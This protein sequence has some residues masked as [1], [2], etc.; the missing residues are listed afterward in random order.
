[1]MAISVVGAGILLPCVRVAEVNRLP[2]RHAS[3][4]DDL[5]E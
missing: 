5:T 3:D 4:V 2:L 1:M